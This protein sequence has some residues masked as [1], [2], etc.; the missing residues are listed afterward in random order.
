M[1]RNKLIFSGVGLLGILILAACAIPGLGSQVVTA[2]PNTMATSISGTALAS[3]HL[4][5][6]AY[7]PTLPPTM[8]LTPTPVISS[9]GTSFEKREDGTAVFTDHRAGIQIVFPSNWLAMRVG[10]KEYY[11]AW[12]K[13]GAQNP[14]LLDAITS[15]Q[16]LDLNRFRITAYDM[17]PDHVLYDNLP[18]I[19][20]VFVEG[21]VRDLKQVE[22]DESSDPSILTG[23]KLLPSEFRKTSAGLDVLL[24]QYQWQSTNSANQ[25]FIGYYRGILFKTASGTVAMDLFIPMDIKEALEAEQQ[26]ILDSVTLLT[27]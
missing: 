21:D 10:E 25:S 6:Q 20:I 7:T 4:T 22:H 11:Q 3:R 18:K 17:H 23:Y 15:T 16:N 8:T 12:E 9:Y 27:P 24:I 26:Q 19:N 14:I 2:T 5:E 13:N 1:Y